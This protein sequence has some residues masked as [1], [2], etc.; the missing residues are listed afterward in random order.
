MAWGGEQDMDLC[1][2]ILKTDSLLILVIL[3]CSSF[4]MVRKL[5]YPSHMDVSSIS[6]KEILHSDPQEASFDYF[7]SAFVCILN[8]EKGYVN[9]PHDPGGE[10]KFGVSKRA[11]PSLDIKNLTYDQA[12]AILYRDYWLKANINLIRDKKVA[13]KLFDLAVNFGVSGARKI[14][15]KALLKMSIRTDDIQAPELIEKSNQCDE[16]Q[17]LSALHNAQISAYMMIVKNNPDRNRD[18]KGWLNRANQTI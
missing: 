1:M 14:W 18:L 8:V 6:S 17:L 5:S 3:M 7:H 2:A 12:S 10:T 16:G 4:L 13:I 9:D 15:C 11:Y